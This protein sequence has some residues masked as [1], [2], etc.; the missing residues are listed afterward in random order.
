MKQHFQTVILGGG[1]AGSAA[2]FLLSRADVSTLMIERSAP[3]G[4]KIG[5]GLPPSSTAL[6]QQ[7]GLLDHFC[8]DGHLPSHG[9]R[10]AWGSAQFAEHSFIFE[11]NG[12]G[13]H[14]D[15]E[16]LDRMLAESAVR[17]GAQRF[18]HTSLINFFQTNDGWELELSNGTTIHAEWVIDATGRNS[19][20][21]HR[22]NVQRQAYDHLVAITGLFITD[23]DQDQDSLTTIE[24]SEHGWW[25]TALLPERR[26]VVAY[27]SDGDLPLTKEARNPDRWQQMLFESTQIGSL[28][29]KHNY[30]LHIPPRMVNANS[31]CLPTAVGD[32]WLAIGDAAAAYDPLSSQGILMALGTALESTEALL[33]HRKGDTRAIPAYADFVNQIYLE[34]LGSRDYFY[35]MEQRFPKSPFWQR[36]THTKRRNP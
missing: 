26:R 11:A 12:H 9:N 29:M 33:A 31:S 30:Q 25:Y 1:T 14:L 28:M 19:H 3:R 35:S 7:F 10:S 15:R 20:F 5:E 8:S 6:L 34:Y 13:W 22:Q 16:K 27:L 21:A 17:Q 18:E 2:A 24:A 32:R 23:H 4:W 36:R